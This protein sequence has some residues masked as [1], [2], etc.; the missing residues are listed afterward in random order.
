MSD[1]FSDKKQ[2]HSGLTLIQ[3]AEKWQ[4]KKKKEKCPK[5]LLLVA[6]DWKNGPLTT[7]GL[8]GRLWLER[9]KP[10]VVSYFL[11]FLFFFSFGNSPC[12]GVRRLPA[13]APHVTR[14][15]WLAARR[16]RM[17][18]CLHPHH[19]NPDLTRRLL[20][21]MPRSLMKKWP[22]LVLAL[23]RRYC[24]TFGNGWQLDSALLKLTHHI[25][26]TPF[27]VYLKKQGLNC[28]LLAVGGVSV[29]PLP[30]DAIVE[31]CM[32]KEAEGHS[33]VEWS[34]SWGWTRPVCSILSVYRTV[35]KPWSETWGTNWCM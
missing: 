19:P 5:L 20:T 32:L 30:R 3:R 7:S 35:R 33:L 8:R 22:G 17:T 2:G 21:W 34:K 23:R 25:H 13:H 28:G 9:N 4:G 14:P 12:V 18:M 31:W 24:E 29:L 6:A 26:D 11:S 15:A 27:L 16:K 10:D 1:F